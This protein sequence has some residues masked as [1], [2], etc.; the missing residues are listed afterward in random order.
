MPTHRA[1]ARIERRTGLTPAAEPAIMPAA[2]NREDALTERDIDR[3]YLLKYILT[4]PLVLATWALGT[5]IAAI[6]L[7]RREW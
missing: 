7:R 4:F 1:S 3:L 5:A 2:P 6:F